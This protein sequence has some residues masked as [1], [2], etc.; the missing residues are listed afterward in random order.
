VERRKEQEVVASPQALYSNVQLI[1][2]NHSPWWFMEDL[3]TERC[4]VESII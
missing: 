4:I 3:E 1:Y 2:F